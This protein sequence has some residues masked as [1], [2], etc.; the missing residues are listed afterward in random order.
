[1]YINLIAVHIPPCATEHNLLFPLIHD[2]I[3]EI[4]VIYIR[5]VKIFRLSDKGGDFHSFWQR[6]DCIQLFLRESMPE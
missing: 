5:T 1:M 3:A 6:C 2:R 4:P